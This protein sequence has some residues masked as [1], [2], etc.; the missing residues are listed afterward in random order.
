MVITSVLELYYKLT[1]RTDI[2]EWRKSS[3]ARMGDLE[4][5]GQNFVSNASRFVHG[6]DAFAFDHHR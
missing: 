3:M 6:H 4:N 2:V 1:S 5:E